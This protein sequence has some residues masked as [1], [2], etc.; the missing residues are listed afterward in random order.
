MSRVE[1]NSADAIELRQGIR[2]SYQ[3]IMKEGVPKLQGAREK[4]NYGNLGFGGYADEKI[5][6]IYMVWEDM[7]KIMPTLSRYIELL[8]KK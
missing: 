4:L 6:Q 2:D 7:G 5:R 3:K 1:G 8:E